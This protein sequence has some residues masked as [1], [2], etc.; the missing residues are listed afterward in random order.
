[1]NENG[2]GDHAA[3]GIVPGVAADDHQSAPHALADERPGIAA[4]SEHAA[5]HAHGLADQ[6]PAR[7][8]ADIAR[9]G[10]AAAGHAGAGQHAGIAVDLDL[11][12]LHAGAEIGA[13]IALDEIAPL[14]MPAPILSQ[15][16]SVPANL[17]SLASLPLTLK[18]SPT[19]S[20]HA[21][22]P[23]RERFD[24]LGLEPV[25]PLGDER[26]RSSL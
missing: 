6:N 1:M 9:D 4:D 23:D 12:A 19:V 17:S 10:D 5:L 26:R 16:P 22:R 13:G 25:E 20:V 2:P 15:R 3:A 7:P 14:V 21:R 24:L 18:P 8:L 11:A